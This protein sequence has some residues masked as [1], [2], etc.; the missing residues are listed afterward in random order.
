MDL[1]KFATNIQFEEGIWYAQTRSAISFPEDGNDYCFKLED[2]SFWFQH[3]N[4]CI[5]EALRR[6]PP[7]NLFFDIGGGNGFVSAAVQAIGC[8]VVLLEPGIQGAK[9]ARLRGIEHVICSSFEDA[10]LLPETMPSAGAFDVVEHVQDDLGFLRSIASRLA[11][12]GRFYLTVP[13]LPILWSQKDEIAGH[14]RR[15]TNAALKRLLPRAGLQIEYVTYFFQLLPLPIL[16]FW[17]IPHR[18]GVRRSPSE[19]ENQSLT[20]HRPSNHFARF[21]QNL[22]TRELAIIRSGRTMTLGSSCLVVARK[23]KH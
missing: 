7:G 17:S 21:L 2:T 16:F 18:L 13:A 9:N 20:D 15:Y 14:Y 19:L 11:P 1:S 23:P 3:R 5:L 12:G 10:G 4:R 8:S 22:Q 6:F